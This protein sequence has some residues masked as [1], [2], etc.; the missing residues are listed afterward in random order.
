LKL[1]QD[2]NELRKK[3]AKWN[4]PAYYFILVSSTL[5]Y[6]YELSKNASMLFFIL[7][8]GGILA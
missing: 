6:V 8:F 3:Q 2:Y 5:V 4:I 7:T 1:W